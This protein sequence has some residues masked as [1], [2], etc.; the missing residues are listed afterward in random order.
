MGVAGT[1]RPTFLG[2]RFAALAHRGG[3]QDPADEA[4]ENTRYAF[5]TALSLGFEFL[6]TDVWA[7][8]DDEL[9]AFH[10]DSLDRVT[11]SSG[12]IGE[13]TWAALSDVR[14]GGRDPIPL[15]AELFEEF[16]GARFNIDLKD[17]RAAPLLADI[18]ARHDAADRVCVASFSTARLRE[19]R[20]LAPTVATAASPTG[21]AVATHVPGVRRF[22]ARRGVALQIPVRYE[23]TPVTLVRPDVI[24]LAHATGRVV[25]VWTVNEEAEMHRLMELGV[26][27]LVSD[28]LTTLKRVVIEHGLWE[29]GS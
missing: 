3:W 28:D 2:R 19:F 15:M 21:V 10:D 12:R 27:G 13:H 18:I 7:T 26:D 16:P 8:A 11:E 17:D 14:I 23:S 25:H 22:W 20:R 5:A 29:G 9:V 24:R 1:E 4:R 6:E